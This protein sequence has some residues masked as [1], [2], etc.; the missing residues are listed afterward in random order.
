[1]LFQRQFA[2]C[3]VTSAHAAA[4]FWIAHWVPFQNPRS[5]WKDSMAS[6]AWVDAWCE[7][8][9]SEAAIAPWSIGRESMAVS[10]AGAPSHQDACQP[11]AISAWSIIWDRKD[12]EWD[13]ALPMISRACGIKQFRNQP[14]LTDDVIHCLVMATENRTCALAHS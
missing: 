9:P 4:T 8:C 14:S 10:V 12:R 13:A 7:L 11:A 2:H 3:W 6:S 1:M 5:V